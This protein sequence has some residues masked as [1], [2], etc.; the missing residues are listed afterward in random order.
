[1][2][3]VVARPDTMA[4]CAEVLLSIFELVEQAGM[5]SLIRLNG[6]LKTEAPIGVHS[7]ARCLRD[8]GGHGTMKIP[9]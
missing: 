8:Q 2:A 7:L 4:R 6:D 5:P 3:R 9:V 1:M